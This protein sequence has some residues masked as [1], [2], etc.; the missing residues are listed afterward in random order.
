[1][2]EKEISSELM[3]EGRIIDVYKQTVMLPDG[4]TAT[5]EVV[6]H[7]PA[8][9]IIPLIDHDRVLLVKQYRK[10]I[11]QELLEFP[12]GISED[13]ESISETA[14]RELEEETGYKS[15]S[16]V[17]LGSCFPAPGFCDEKLFF[18]LATSLVKT[19]THFDDDEYLSLHSMSIQECKEAID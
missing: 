11:N 10:A 2:I 14:V 13:E 16:V 19:Q 9:V 6:M 8:A 18:F 15:E 17:L 3:F 5:R 1:M 4:K 7:K 12:A